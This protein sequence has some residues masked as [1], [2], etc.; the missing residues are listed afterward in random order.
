MK[1]PELPVNCLSHGTV[2]KKKKD[3]LITSSHFDPVLLQEE[4]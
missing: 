2:E 1:L 4:T 3:S